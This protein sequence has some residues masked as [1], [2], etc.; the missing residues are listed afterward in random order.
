VGELIA[1]AAYSAG[2]KVQDIR[3]EDSGE[4]AAKP[5]HFV[6]IGLHDPN[7]QEL[8]QLQRQFGLHELAIEDALTAHQRPKL[9]QYGETTFLVLRTAFLLGERIGLGETE[10]FVGRG[11]V[12][13]VRHGESA[14]YARV[15]QCAESAPKR[16]A[17][18]E[19][20]VLYAII[21]FIVD[22]YLVVVDRLQDEAEALED[23]IMQP[24][25]DEAK[26]GRIYR[27]RRDLQRLRLAVAPTAE[28]C[29]RLE[30]VDL[31]GVDPVFRPY[32]LD[33]VDHTNRSLEQL[34]TLR[35]RLTFAFEATFL[36]ESARQ[37]DVNRRL[38]GWAA[39][40]AVPTMIAGIY[41]MNFKSMPELEWAWGY[42]AAVLLMAAVC[43][44]LFYRF[45]RAGWV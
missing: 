24:P 13:S 40:L 18:G 10:I 45:R 38:A 17:N 20:Y 36:A 4:W 23:A 39:I 7:E 30:H 12:I 33:I 44:Y 19:D 27:L 22:N 2:R 31:P 28:V 42:P 34:D 9:E 5:G 32:Y 43:G 26:I 3:L 14:S 41:G 21:D 29:K 1:A 15:R 35:E 6:W 16:L 8:R 25:L 11:Y 37:G